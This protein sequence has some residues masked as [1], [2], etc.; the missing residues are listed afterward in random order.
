MNINIKLDICKITPKIKKPLQDMTMDINKDQIIQLYRNQGLDIEELMGSNL[1]KVT[2]TITDEQQETDFEFI[3]D[4]RTVNLEYIK[5]IIQQFRLM[6]QMR[7]AE[8]VYPEIILNQN[9]FRIENI[10]MS[11]QKAT[12]KSCDTSQLKIVSLEALQY[13]QT[14]KIEDEIAEVDLNFQ[15]NFITTR[16]ALSQIK[17]ISETTKY[18]FGFSNTLNF[19]TTELLA[20]TINKIIESTQIDEIESLILSWEKTDLET[21]L[22]IVQSSK[23]YIE[24]MLNLDITYI[25]TLSQRLDHYEKKARYKIETINATNTVLE[26]LT[27]Y[28]QCID[29]MPKLWF[30]LQEERNTFLI[31]I[32]QLKSV[33]ATIPEL[34][35]TITVLA[36][37]IR[38][39]L[40]KAE[41]ESV[42]LLS[43]LTRQTEEIIQT[44]S[45]KTL[46]Q[47]I[48]K[49]EILLENLKLKNIQHTQKS[50]LIG[51]QQEKLLEQYQ[52]KIPELYANKHFQLPSPTHY[53]DTIKLYHTLLNARLEW[54]SSLDINQK[55]ELTE[56][57]EKN[58]ENFYKICT[59]KLTQ[60]NLALFL[61]SQ[62]KREKQNK[63][64]QFLSKIRS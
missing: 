26:L 13:A 50:L 60:K 4:T 6:T 11:T 25:N 35:K 63:W 48:N 55:E 29:P 20:R 19:R 44:N 8:I 40:K 32:N 49:L 34:V 45:P 38:S 42:L 52:I 54:L 41:L 7:A 18:I 15:N 61:N 64:E 47:T 53:Q 56:I 30:D 24:P 1:K 27:S 59:Q 21:L 37:Q 43:P 22:E 31:R 28:Q 23:G 16:E 14:S 9:E 39:K 17:K 62:E 10:D 12:L 33:N 2:K 46:E 58:P 36:E 5:K 57:A 51:I 3:F